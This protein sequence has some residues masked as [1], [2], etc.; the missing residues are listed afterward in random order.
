MLRRYLLKVTHNDCVRDHQQVT[1]VTLSGF[2]LLSK[3][4]PPPTPVLN[5]QYQAGWNTN[6]N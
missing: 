4:E 6:Q 5:G 3:H 2:W 1:F